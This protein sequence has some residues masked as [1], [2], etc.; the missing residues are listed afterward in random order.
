[1]IE[2]LTPA[3][4][5]RARRTGTLVADILQTLRERSVCRM[6]APTSSTSTAGPPR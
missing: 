6:S 3:Q 2:I 5:D 1:M 4:V